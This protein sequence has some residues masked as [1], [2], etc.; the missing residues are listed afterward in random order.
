MSGGRLFKASDARAIRFGSR[1]V[2][3]RQTTCIKQTP[4][5]CQMTIEPIGLIAL[6][7]GIISLFFGPAFI[8]YV[9]V[10]STLLGS[11]GAIILDFIGGTNIQPAHLLLG[12]LVFKL[13]TSQAVTQRASEGLAIGRPGFW[14]LL[15]AL[16][17][18]LSAYAMPRIFAGETFVFAV[19]AQSAYS[20]PLG[21]TTSNLTQTVYFIGNLVCFYVLY[22]YASD[23]ANRRNLA[24]AGLFCC[25]LNLVF[26]VLDLATYWT[27]TTELL[28]FIRN[29]TYALLNDSEI[30][31]FKRIVG[32]FTEASSFGYAT[33]GYFAFASTFWLYGFA[34]AFMLPLSLLLFLALMFSTSTTAYAGLVGLLAVMYFQTAIFALLRSPTKQMT[35]F[36]IAA[37]VVL[38]L[39]FVGISLNDDSAKYVGNMLDSML[40]NKLSTESGIERSSWNRQAFQ[41]FLDTFGFG[42]GNGSVRASSFPVAVIASLGFIGTLAYGA[43]LLS[44]LFGN[45][46]RESSDLFE[47]AVPHAAKSACIAWLIAATVSGALIDLGLPF[48]VFSALACAR[49]GTRKGKS[50]V[51]M[52]FA[53]Y[54]SVRSAAGS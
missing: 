10:A 38:V 45:R 18:L 17:S 7:L 49:I 16:Y 12:F 21:P 53:K 9:F 32:S 27:G 14:L 40:L 42:A 39:A 52:Q 2:P 13:S 23:E 6:A 30:Q 8:V 4:Q 36:L 22:G 33:L 37:P 20:I 47:N 48:F 31:G 51:D 11:A 50:A 3:L 5:S 34:P 15:T 28:S 1:G 54:G 44:V 19:R 24:K 46:A 29:A 35:I 26:A 25:V 41:N 43:F